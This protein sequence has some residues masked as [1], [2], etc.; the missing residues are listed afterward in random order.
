MGALGA[1]RLAPLEIREMHA[2][3]APPTVRR[4][5]EHL[6]FIRLLFSSASSFLPLSPLPS[7]SLTRDHITDALAKSPDGGATL[8]LAYKG[9]SDVGESGAEEL[10][11]VGQDKHTGTESTVVRS[12]SAILFFARSV[13]YTL[14]SE[15]RSPI[16]ASPLYLWLF[17]YCLACAIL[18]SRIIVLLSFLMSCVLRYSPFFR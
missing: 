8:D 10:A 14:S 1:G 15:L 13:S 17:P 9:L 2:D 6:S 7:L 5:C 16:I 18:S 11:T 12:V 4:T 3:G